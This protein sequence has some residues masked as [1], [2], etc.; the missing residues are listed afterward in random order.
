[1]PASASPVRRAELAAEIVA[2]GAGMSVEHEQ[3]LVLGRQQP[4]QLAQR[5]VLQDVGEIARRDSRG[6]SSWHRL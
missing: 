1:M 4:Q 2:A 5:R 3:L 6:G